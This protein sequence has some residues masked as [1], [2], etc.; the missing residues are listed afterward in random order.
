MQMLLK[1]HYKGVE[2]TSSE[3]INC[4]KNCN[5]PIKCTNCQLVESSGIDCII[6]KEAAQML[7]K[8]ADTVSDLR[9]EV[10]SFCGEF[11]IDYLP[12]CRCHHCRWKELLI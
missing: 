1:Q 3:L 6:M 2:M 4:L 10:C 8:Y 7:K 12:E 9:N 11:K 5:N